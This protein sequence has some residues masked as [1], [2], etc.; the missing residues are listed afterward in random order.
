MS[1]DELE[2]L[3]DLLEKIVRVEKL[4]LA[5]SERRAIIKVIN[6]ADALAAKRRV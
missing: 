1:H 6:A 5:E 3:A 2:K 4:E